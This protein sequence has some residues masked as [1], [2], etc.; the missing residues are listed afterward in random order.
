MRSRGSL[1]IL[2]DEATAYSVYSLM[3]DFVLFIDRK[4]GVKY[5]A[6]NNNFVRIDEALGRKN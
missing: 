2:F 5:F 4:G 3:F 6:N 1:F